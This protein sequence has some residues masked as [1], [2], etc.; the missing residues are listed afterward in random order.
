[1]LLFF[2]YSL[3]HK[4]FKTLNIYC[5]KVNK[6]LLTVGTVSLYIISNIWSIIKILVLWHFFINYLCSFSVAFYFQHPT[7]YIAWWV[8][9]P[10]NSP[11]QYIALWLVKP[12]NNTILYTVLWVVIPNDI[13]ILYTA[14]WVVTPD[15]SSIF[16]I[17]W[18]VV[19]PDYSSIFY[20]AWWVVIPDN[21]PTLHGEW[22]YLIKTIYCI[23]LWVIYQWAPYKI[24]YI[25]F[26]YFNRICQML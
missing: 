18:W 4:K 20:T 9:T 17:A 26:G 6:Y 22:E 23:P 3:K 13:P 16:Y 21:S 2:L 25:T 7:M 5:I 24:S 19:I 1:M 15:Y 10:E 14:W 11:M 12:G 8:V